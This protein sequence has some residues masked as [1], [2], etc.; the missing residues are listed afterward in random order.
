MKG[1]GKAWFAVAFQGGFTV[2][3]SKYA[4]YEEL[5]LAGGNKWYPDFK[6]RRP[7]DGKIIIWE[8]FGMLDDVDYAVEN[9]EKLIIYME[10]GFRLLDNLIVTYDERGGLDMAVLEKLCELVLK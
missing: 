8:H 2:L 3:L 1:C 4:Q 9:Q 5:L 7:R 10:Y 6:V